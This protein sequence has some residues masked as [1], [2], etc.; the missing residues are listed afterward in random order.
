MTDWD[1]NP[2]DAQEYYSEE[3]DCS[4][5]KVETSWCAEDV[6]CYFEEDVAHMTDEEVME[7]LESLHNGFHNMCVESG[8]NVIAYCFNIKE[9]K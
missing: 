6:R 4:V 5:V 9:K 3:P 1:C 7:E 2:R 8:W